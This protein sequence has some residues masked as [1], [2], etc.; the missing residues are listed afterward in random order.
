MRLNRATLDQ[1]VATVVAAEQS[2]DK[3]AHSKIRNTRVPAYRASSSAII[4]APA[5]A[6]YDIVADYRNGHP[7]ILPKPYFLGL[8]GEQGGYG[9][10][11]IINFQMRV[12]GRT[13]SFRAEI[14]E[15]QPG[16][17]LVEKN[18]GANGAVST[19][20]VVPCKGDTAQVTI[21]TSGATQREGLLGAFE[22]LVTE[23]YLKRIYRKE[24]QQLAAFAEK[25]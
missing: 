14:S 22:R 4:P 15:P 18:L 24:L 6:V 10:G 8:Q 16:R 5:R 13:Q 21:S 12:G 1:P 9:A 19:F 2:V 11:T 20:E 25:R 23:F 3:A 7:Y 17:V